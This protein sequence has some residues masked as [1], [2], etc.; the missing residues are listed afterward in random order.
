M[1][2]AQA[3]QTNRQTNKLANEQTNRQTDRQTGKNTNRE[4]NR[5]K[6]KSRM[7]LK[8][9]FDGYQIAEVKVKMPEASPDE[10]RLE[11]GTH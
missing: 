7:L 5:K 2:E 8:Q 11:A 1:L 4:T 9:H 10:S 3:K 6:L